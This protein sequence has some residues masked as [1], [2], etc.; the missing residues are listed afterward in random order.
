MALDA[1]CKG[2]YGGLAIVL[3]DDLV[4]PQVL[5]VEVD[6]LQAVF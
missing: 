6:V 5:E 4:I 2:S 3:E 1:V